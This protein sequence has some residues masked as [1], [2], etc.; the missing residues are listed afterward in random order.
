MENCGLVDELGSSVL[1]EGTSRE[2]AGRHL[3]FT[4]LYFL[5]KSHPN[6]LAESCPKVPICLAC[7]MPVL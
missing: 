7:M 2:S 1:P 3:C 6:M 5:I 4:S